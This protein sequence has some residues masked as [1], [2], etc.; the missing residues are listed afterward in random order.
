MIAVAGGPAEAEARH[1]EAWTGC[2]RSSWSVLV[3]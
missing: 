1:P 2:G 3:I